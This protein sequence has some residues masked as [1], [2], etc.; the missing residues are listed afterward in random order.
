MFP[1]KNTVS[2]QILPG[3]IVF[4]IHALF[5]ALIAFQ[6]SGGNAFRVE[7]SFPPQKA[8]MWPGIF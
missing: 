6:I 7:A 5:F 8:D 1:V 2:T 3:V 4:P